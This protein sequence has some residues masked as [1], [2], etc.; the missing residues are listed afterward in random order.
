MIFCRLCC[1]LLFLNYN[2][3]F[4]P[5][6]IKK[7]KKMRPQSGSDQSVGNWLG[8]V[9]QQLQQ[10]KA[11]QAKRLQNAQRRRQQTGTDAMM[12]RTESI[13]PPRS[14]KNNEVKILTNQMSQLE[15]EYL[16][17]AKGLSNKLLKLQIENDEYS[18]QGSILHE[19]EQTIEIAT[20]EL[21]L[22]Y[23]ELL[24][25]ECDVKFITMCNNEKTDFCE[26]LFTY[27]NSLTKIQS[28]QHQSSMSSVTNLLQMQQDGSKSCRIENESLKQEV[29]NLTNQLWIESSSMM[30]TQ[31][32]N[33]ILQNNLE[34]ER[35]TIINLKNEIESEQSMR[36]A[37]ELM[38]HAA[39]DKLNMAVTAAVSES[40]LIHKKQSSILTSNISDLENQLHLSESQLESELH[41]HE[42]TRTLISEIQQQFADD[43]K[44][45]IN[46]HTNALIQKEETV[47]REYQ[48]ETSNAITQTEV[49]VKTSSK[50]IQVAPPQIQMTTAEVQTT[51]LSNLCR[52]AGR[53]LELAMS[54][55]QQ[56]LEQIHAQHI[57]QDYVKLRFSSACFAEE[58]LSIALPANSNILPL[59]SVEL[60]R[61][62]DLSIVNQ[63]TVMM[64]I[65]SVGTFVIAT[66]SLVSGRAVFTEVT[67][68]EACSGK[69]IS[70][71]LNSTDSSHPT[72]P[73]L[74]TGIVVMNDVVDDNSDSS[75]VAAQRLLRYKL[76]KLRQRHSIPPMRSLSASHFSSTS[77][78]PVFADAMQHSA[79][80]TLPSRSFSQGDFVV[81]MPPPD[82]PK[83]IDSF[84]QQVP[85]H[86]HPHQPTSGVI[87]SVEVVP[88]QQVMQTS[89]QVTV[90]QRTD[91][92][93]QSE[94]HSELAAVQQTQN[95]HQQHQQT[96]FRQPSPASVLQNELTAV[97]QTPQVAQQQLQQ[98][99]SSSLTAVPQN[100]VVPLSQQVI[101]VGDNS[102][103]AQPISSIAPQQEA[104][105]MEQT[106]QMTQQPEVALSQQ[107]TSQ[108]DSRQP[109]PP[110]EVTATQQTNPHITQ[111]SVA[112]LQGEVAPQQVASQVG[113]VADAQPPTS[114]AP[115][116]AAAVQLVPQHHSSSR[117][118]Q[119]VEPSQL[120]ASTSQSDVVN[121]TAAQQSDVPKVG[122]GAQPTSQ[123]SE[124]DQSQHS[125]SEISLRSEAEVPQ[126]AVR[127]ADD[128]NSLPSSQVSFSR[129]EVDVVQPPQ[130]DEKTMKSAD[131]IK[132]SSSLLPL[133]ISSSHSDFTEEVSALQKLAKE[134]HTPPSRTSIEIESPGIVSP[135]PDPSG[136]LSRDVLRVLHQRVAEIS[137]AVGAES[138]FY[139]LVSGLLEEVTELRAEL[140]PSDSKI[141]LTLPPPT[142][143]VLPST[144]VCY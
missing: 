105:V 30:E 135:P 115:Q 116:Q 144:E 57:N 35:E 113:N 90:S 128:Q 95:Q 131:V 102:I 130:F 9:N 15:D 19:T 88:P 117:V 22:I 83:Q 69:S 63:H 65:A 17:E 47:R 136:G 140:Y 10:Q 143:A 124:A 125:S 112:V 18:K 78:P 52:T 3:S 46:K 118:V 2:F 80:E 66:S 70:F 81:D 20:R 45:T 50:N 48:K 137:A 123:V 92:V 6:D 12:V 122:D 24:E 53:N 74:S 82:L 27:Y 89:S 84:Q 54:G 134:M 60:V 36:L 71:T 120:A 72:V 8:T 141:P 51:D 73:L 39:D 67:V 100:E 26:I 104:A 94:E 142:N 44:S 127:I 64:V 59:V 42:Q 37:S 98:S 106:S 34:T 25:R 7:K 61:V 77:P 68:P 21:S 97:Q 1:V 85:L 111:Q 32:K 129:D 96:D 79:S 16:S 121:Q 62:N 4:K 109:S 23:F 126:Q 86:P 41:N 31:G 5:C 91:N 11:E 132:Q 76:S 13:S 40:Q 114:V 139:E 58:G 110:E 103:D 33:K 107:V 119:N 56:E 101:T 28:S 38:L 99:S 138:P 55:R 93:L 87:Q 29:E 49:L 14:S 43:I 75:R 133:E 108:S